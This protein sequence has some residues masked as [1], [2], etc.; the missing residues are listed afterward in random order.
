MLQRYGKAAE[1][2][3]RSDLPVRRARAFVWRLEDHPNEGR[4]LTGARI[5]AL[6]GVRGLAILLVILFHHTLMRP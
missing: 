4:S 3:T 1:R 6:D 5:P 2:Q